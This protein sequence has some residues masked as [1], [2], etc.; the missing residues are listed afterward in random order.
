MFSSIKIDNNNLIIEHTPL[1]NVN[2][3]LRIGVSHVSLMNSLISC[4][5]LNSLK[6]LKKIK[7]NI[8]IT[9][10]SK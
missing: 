10:V 8:N 7:E 2:T 5:F 6:L 3:W 1:Q 9:I 4:S